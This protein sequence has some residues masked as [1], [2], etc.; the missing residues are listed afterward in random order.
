ME[1]DSLIQPSPSFQQLRLAGEHHE[2]PHKQL[3]RPPIARPVLA[4]ERKKERKKAALPVRRPVSLYGCRVSSA[5]RRRHRRA[6]HRRSSSHLPRHPLHSSPSMTS[7]PL[8]K[9]IRLRRAA[10]WATAPT[11]RASF[12]VASCQPLLLLLLYRT[13][14]KRPE[15]ALWRRGTML[16]RHS[17]SSS[18]QG[19]A[20]RCRYPVRALT[21]AHDMSEH[22]GMSDQ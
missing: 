22:G 8:Q 20:C 13:V 18:L 3:I 11:F 7:R 16:P 4:G 9:N 6:R 15:K 1:R 14:A 19:H 2:Q 12:S 21:R 5:P 10:I 17:P